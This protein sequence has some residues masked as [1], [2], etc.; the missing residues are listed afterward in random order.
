VIHIKTEEWLDK[1]SL[2]KNNWDGYDATAVP[3]QIINLCKDMADKFK[4]TP[5]IYPTCRATIQFEFDNGDNYLELEIFTDHY[6][7]L[8][9][10]DGDEKEESGEIDLDKIN[11]LIEMIYRKD[12]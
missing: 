7:A 12:N 1:I 8:I 5:E 4:Y 2:L 6:E 10:C 3:I 11:K 9:S